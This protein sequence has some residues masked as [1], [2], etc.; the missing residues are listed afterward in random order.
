[1]A[2][3]QVKKN[4]VQGRTRRKVARLQAKEMWHG[5]KQ[6]KESGTGPSI[7]KNMWKKKNDTGLSKEKMARDQVK[8][9]WHGVKQKKCDTGPNKGEVA[10]AKQRKRVTG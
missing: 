4:V 9:R 3:G 5:A 1:M 10:V 8:G 2:R 7:K 6:N